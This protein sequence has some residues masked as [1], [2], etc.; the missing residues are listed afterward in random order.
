MFDKRAAISVLTLFS[1]LWFL[2]LL[3]E[4]AVA[5]AVQKRSVGGKEASLKSGNSLHERL[6]AECPR[7]CSHTR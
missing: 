7:D 2:P 6:E 4:L 1:L 5:E 3:F